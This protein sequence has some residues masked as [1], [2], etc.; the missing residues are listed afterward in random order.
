MCAGTL[1]Q[2]FSVLLL[3]I[4]ASLHSKVNKR[5]E[6]LN[7]QSYDPL[8]NDYVCC[9][10]TNQYKQKMVDCFPILLVHA[11]VHR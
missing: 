4:S 11:F 3:V 1:E 7:L 10:Y 6:S 9:R 2:A 8:S 5:Q